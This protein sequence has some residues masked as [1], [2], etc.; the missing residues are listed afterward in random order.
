M[1]QLVKASVG[2]LLLI[3]VTSQGAQT[4]EQRR[5]IT[6]GAPPRKSF[7]ATDRSLVVW[8]Q[9]LFMAILQ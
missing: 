5:V 2:V 9:S 7:K 4:M 1:K 6:A 8:T 3:L